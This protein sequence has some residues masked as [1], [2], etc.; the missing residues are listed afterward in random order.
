M[1][2]EEGPISGGAAPAGAPSEAA[3]A[4]RGH[5]LVVEHNVVNQAVARRLLE[6]MG[7]DVDVASDGGEAVAA[8]KSTAFDL[9]LMDYQM[10]VMDGYEATVAIRELPGEV[11]RTPIVAMTAKTMKGDREM[12]LAAGMDDYIAKPVS[13]KVLQKVVEHW[14][15]RVQARR[16]SRFATAA[17]A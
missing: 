16:P 5:I 12:C 6:R 15:E 9:I 13:P 2:Y 14:L 7:H 11:A 3:P 8:A 1:M 17:E 4:P 10:P